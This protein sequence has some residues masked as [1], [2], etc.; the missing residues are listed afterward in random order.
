[1]SLKSFISDR[2]VLRNLLQ[3]FLSNNKREKGN[4]TRVATNANIGGVAFLLP[5]IILAAL[6]V[7]LKL[8]LAIYETW[9][10]SY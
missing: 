6:W 8:N 4:L 1:M 5:S 9:E 2:V 10:I 3:F 7:A